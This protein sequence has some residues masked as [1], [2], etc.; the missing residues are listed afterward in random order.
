VKVGLDKELIRRLINSHVMDVRDCYEAGLVAHPERRGRIFVTFT[1]SETGAVGVS[2][3]QRST[4]GDPAI[5]TCVGR[6]AC[7]WQFPKPAGGGIVIVTYPFNFTPWDP[8][9]HR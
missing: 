1:I 9:T 2:I 3:I 5:E 8:A 6:Q 7:R 4:L